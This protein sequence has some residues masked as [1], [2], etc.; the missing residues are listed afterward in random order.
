MNAPHPHIETD[1]RAVAM[2][3]ASVITEE[4][5]AYTLLIFQVIADCTKTTTPAVPAEVNESLAA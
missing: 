4:R 1:W 5:P 2:F 3:L